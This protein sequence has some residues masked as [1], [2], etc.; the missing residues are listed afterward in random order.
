MLSTLLFWCGLGCLGYWLL[1]INVIISDGWD[2]MAKATAVGWRISLV[3]FVAA[4]IAG[5]LSLLLAI[6]ACKK[7]QKHE[8]KVIL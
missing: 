8:E 3:M 1:A 6:A 7:M 4:L 5:P 2:S